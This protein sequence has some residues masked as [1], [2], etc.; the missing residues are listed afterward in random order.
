LAGVPRMEHAGCSHPTLLLGY[1]LLCAAQPR[2][3]PLHK[4][5]FI[6]HFQQHQLV[7]HRAADTDTL[8][9]FYALL[10]FVSTSSMLIEQ[11]EDY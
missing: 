11:V 6:A 4:S 3:Y 2:R 1:I 9:P 10:R 8:H 5:R 7:N